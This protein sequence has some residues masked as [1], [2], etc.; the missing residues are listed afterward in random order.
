[1]CRRRDAPVGGA[2]E[3]EVDVHP[4]AVLDHA[5]RPGCG[6]TGQGAVRVGVDRVGLRTHLQN[7]NPA[8]LHLRSR[9]SRLGG[10]RLADRILREIRSRFQ[11]LRDRLLRL[12][13]PAP[14]AIVRNGQIRRG[15]QNR[16]EAV[17]KAT[18]PARQVVFTYSLPLFSSP[19]A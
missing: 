13:L 2:L 10:L 19:T 17:I 8:V 16:V 3:V 11:Q 4:A 14:A 5:D 12:G 9:Q 18:L 1:M 6:G 15:K 7:L